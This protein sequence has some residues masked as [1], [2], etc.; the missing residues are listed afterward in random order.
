M[1]IIFIK[2]HYSAGILSLMANVAV[3]VFPGVHKEV[4]M[5]KRSYSMV[6]HVLYLV[7]ALLLLLGQTVW[8]ADF[9][10]LMIL[11]TNDSHGYDQGAE[12]HIGMP[13]IAQIKKDMEAKGYQVVLLDAGD[14]I[15]GNDI[16][17][18]DQG[19]SIIQYM[20]KAGYDAATLGNHEFDYGQAVLKDRMRE[21]SF[22]FVSCNVLLEK[23]GED[24]TQPT[25]ILDKPGCRIGI[26]GLT[27]PTTQTSTL[28]S[29]VAGLKFLGNDALY[30]V[31]QGHVDRLRAAGCD[32]IIALGHMGSNDDALGSRSE[33]VISHVKGIDIFID[34]HDHLVKNNYLGKTLQAETGCYTA[35]LGCIVWEKGRWQEKMIPYGKYTQPDAQVEQQVQAT[36]QA[37]DAAYGKIVA[38][39][40]VS[41]DGARWPG[42]RNQEMNV[43]DFCADMVFWQAAQVQGL[44]YP[45]DGALLNGGAVRTGL[46]AGPVSLRQLSDIMP[47]GTELVIVQLKGSKLLELLEAGT[48]LTPREMGAF[49]QVSGIEY[50]LDT[51]VPY[52][53][54][55]QYG[56]STYYSPAAPGTRVTIKSVGGKPFQ[57]NA[58]YAIAITRFIFEGGDSYGGIKEP[59]AI[60]S[61]VGTG[62]PDTDALLNYVTQGLGGV[63]GEE[64]RAPQGR[65]VI[66]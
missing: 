31:V 61:V 7:L 16:A 28:P 66:K 5:M 52:A 64:Y 35:K 60:I 1:D 63:I 26:V 14:I 46:P 25:L 42:L 13:V 10:K 62:I 15:Q 6:K 44:G 30:A 55:V 41:L 57:P 38:V 24:F 4:V 50:S 17:K 9:S 39:A 43:G 8:A 27:T 58:V 32:L 53:Q 49:P 19:K 18:F 40:K 56:Q 51:A 22:P 65:I 33:D 47:F 54:G 21:A 29:Y 59:G 45:V 20:N 12:N 34:G 36:L 11:H 2:K 37:I 23:T 48:Q 3:R